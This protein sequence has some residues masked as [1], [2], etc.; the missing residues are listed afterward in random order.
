MSRALLLTVG[1]GNIDDLEA[2]LFTPLRI[3][4]ERG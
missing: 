3:S 4:V 2:S 1:T